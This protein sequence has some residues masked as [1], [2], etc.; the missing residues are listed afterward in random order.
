[1]HDRLRQ[2]RPEAGS[3]SDDLRFQFRDRA[4]MLEGLA[5]AQEMS[6]IESCLVDPPQLVLEVRLEPGVSRTSPRAN[7]WLAHMRRL[8]GLR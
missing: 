2:P 5:T 4:A 3:A 8:T 7:R 6:W 1:M